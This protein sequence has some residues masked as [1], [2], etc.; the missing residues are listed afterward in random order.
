[1]CAWDGSPRPRKSPHARRAQRGS[2]DG[3]FRNKIRVW[4]TRY[5]AGLATCAS[6]WWRWRKLKLTSPEGR[7]RIA[8][9]DAI[10]VRG[11]GPS[12]EL[13]P[14][15][16]IA[17]QSDLSPT[18]RGDLMLQRGLGDIPEEAVQRRHHLRALADRAADTLHRAGADVANREHAGHRGFQR[19]DRLSL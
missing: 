2:D 1:M 12:S 3:C 6:L 16:R 14:L 11:Y 19:G 8:S 18:G 17:S 5:S 9:Q 4:Q 13:R 7:G 15:T 10:R